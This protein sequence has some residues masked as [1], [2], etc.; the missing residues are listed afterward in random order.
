MCT[1]PAGLIDESVLEYEAA[2]AGIGADRQADRMAEQLWARPRQRRQAR[3]TIEF[4]IAS[5]IASTARLPARVRPFGISPIRR[6]P[7]GAP[8]A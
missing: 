8:L 4:A 6:P 3:I 1:W 2:P 7:S 5:A